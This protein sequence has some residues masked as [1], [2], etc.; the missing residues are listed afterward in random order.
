AF[1]RELV[2]DESVRRDVLETVADYRDRNPETITADDL[3]FDVDAWAALP[4][5]SRPVLNPEGLCPG[6]VLEN[7]Y[8]F[9]GV[10]AEMQ[11]LFERV[12][13]E[14]SGDAVSRVAYTP[15]PEASV[16]D[17]VADAR[18][19]FDVTVGSYPDTERQNRLKVT[20][21]DH[22]TVDRALEWLAD[23]IELDAGE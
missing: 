18:E 2:V 20:G 12:A 15:Q 7:V 23:R 13:A 14:F 19:R 22:E 16:V 21:T 1:D 5:G 3:D 11:A 10:P 4:E 9:P 6:C 17:A 8:A